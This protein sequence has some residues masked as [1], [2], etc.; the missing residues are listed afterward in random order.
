MNVMTCE[1]QS[2]NSSALRSVEPYHHTSTGGDGEGGIGFGNRIEEG[3]TFK[4]WNRD[5]GEWYLR[6]CHC[7]C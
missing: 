3:V 7:G 5:V 2:K 1:G 6:V 4:W